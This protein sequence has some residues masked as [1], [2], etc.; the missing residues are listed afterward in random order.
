MEKVK[1]L[2]KEVGMKQSELAFNLGYCQSNYS[3]IENGK[4]ITNTMP[5]LEEDAVKILKP[6]LIKKILFIREDLE[7]LEY[8]LLQLN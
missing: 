2:R 6:L 1:R 7:R 8:L 3:K 5:K 4:L